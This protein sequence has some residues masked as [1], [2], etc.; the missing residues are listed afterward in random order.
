MK[1]T[2]SLKQGAKLKVCF[3]HLEFKKSFNRRCFDSKGQSSTRSMSSLSSWPFLSKVICVVRILFS[4]TELYLFHSH[5]A[6]KKGSEVSWK[7]TV[8]KIFLFHRVGLGTSVQKITNHW[9]LSWTWIFDRVELT[10]PYPHS[11][12][13]N[14]AFDFFYLLWH[15]I[16]SFLLYST[17]MCTA[18]SPHFPPRERAVVIDSDLVKP[19]RIMSDHLHYASLPYHS[20]R[21]YGVI[22]LTSRWQELLPKIVCKWHQAWGSKLTLFHFN[23][24]AFIFL[25][26]F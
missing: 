6:I 16:E 25:A 15:F 3:W 14:H 2:L 10:S 21:S 26:L 4:A 8:K 20:T 7:I 23:L 9:D 12:A 11:G 13:Q 19:R 1:G 17:A 5:N 22:L 18:I 24:R